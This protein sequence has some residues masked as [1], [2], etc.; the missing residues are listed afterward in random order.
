MYL[1]IGNLTHV[2]YYKHKLDHFSKFPKES[3]IGIYTQ[4]YKLTENLR[5]M[6]T[7]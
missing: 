1:Q 4:M 6:V 2:P 3:E 5:Y 7:F